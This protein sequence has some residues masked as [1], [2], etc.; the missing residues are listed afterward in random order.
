MQKL[1]ELW[2]RQQYR[3]Q[4]NTSESSEQLTSVLQHQQRAKRLLTGKGPSFCMSESSSEHT[5]LRH[6]LEKVH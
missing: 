1:R 6:V 5:T 3:D 2:R 4:Y